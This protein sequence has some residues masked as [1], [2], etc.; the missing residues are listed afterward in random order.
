MNEFIKLIEEYFN[1][2]FN[3]N[4]FIGIA[5]AI[6][7]LILEIIYMNK[8]KK[9]NKKVEKAKQ[10]GNII[11][12]KRVHT[13]TDNRHGTSMDSWVYA[14]YTYE[15]SGKSYHYKYMER[16][17]AP[18]T[19]TLYYINNPRKV[20]TGKAKKNIFSSLL[21]YLIPIAVAVIVINMLGGV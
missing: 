1:S 7:V 19:L 6:V 14:T 2:V 11:T 8:H 13:W 9:I 12:A 4:V 15:V 20:F 21:F 17:F 5:A 18:V 3:L 10:L 16:Q